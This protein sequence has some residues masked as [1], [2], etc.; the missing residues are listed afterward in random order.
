M[1]SVCNHPTTRILC[2]ILFVIEFCLFCTVKIKLK[3]KLLSS[4]NWHTKFLQFSSANELYQKSFLR[5]FWYCVPPWALELRVATQT[6]LTEKP[7]AEYLNLL[8][9]DY[10]C[11]SR[12]ET[13]TLRC[14][15]LS[16]SSSA[17]LSSLSTEVSCLL[18]SCSS[19][20]WS[21]TLSNNVSL[22][23]PASWQQTL[24]VSYQKN[25]WKS[26]WLYI[27]TLKLDQICGA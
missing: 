15:N 22:S 20:L 10:T 27:L 3:T 17:L 19:A 4:D 25:F 8:F 14:L 1:V 7:E 26:Q 6:T 9:K 23:P 12:A 21:L 13:S 16:N 18:T 5:T 24:L 11:V 2:K